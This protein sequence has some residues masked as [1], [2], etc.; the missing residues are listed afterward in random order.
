MAMMRM[1]TVADIARPAMRGA[2]ENTRNL[3]AIVTYAVAGRVREALPNGP[4]A[5]AWA[6]TQ[7]SAG[8]SRTWVKTHWR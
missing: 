3:V 6:L 4:V 8:T 7:E 1:V 5:V 2:G